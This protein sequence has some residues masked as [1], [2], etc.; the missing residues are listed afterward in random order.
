MPSVHS[1]IVFLYDG[2]TCPK[3]ILS[4]VKM[5]KGKAIAQTSRIDK[6]KEVDYEG[7]LDENYDVE[8]EEAFSFIR[9]EDEPG[10]F[11]WPTEK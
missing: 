10:H 1:Q 9:I 4:P 11:L 2:E 5:E 7:D 8:D 3:G 6:N